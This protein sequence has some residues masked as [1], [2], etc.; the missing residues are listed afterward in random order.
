MYEKTKLGIKT[1]AVR[2]LLL[3]RSEEMTIGWE[4]G[5]G[6]SDLVSFLIAHILEFTT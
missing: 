1:A 4:Y 3:I 5:G 2:Q 6:L